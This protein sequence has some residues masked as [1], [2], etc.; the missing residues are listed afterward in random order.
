MIFDK[1]SVSCFPVS[2]MGYF[3]M[4]NVQCNVV[5]SLSEDLRSNIL[6]KNIDIF[7][8]FLF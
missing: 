3:L 1:V 7:P 6:G 5:M 8:T 4:V 2:S